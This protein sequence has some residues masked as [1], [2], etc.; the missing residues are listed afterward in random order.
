[1]FHERRFADAF[2]P[3]DEHMSAPRVQPPKLGDFHF[4][5]GKR[6]RE[7]HLF[8]CGISLSQSARCNARGH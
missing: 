8:S 7:F 5:T 1:M 2:R 3:G 6:K 4:S